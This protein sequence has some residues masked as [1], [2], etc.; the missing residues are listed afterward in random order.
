MGRRVGWGISAYW[1]QPALLH[2]LAPKGED[3]LASLPVLLHSQLLPPLASPCIL[4][5]NSEDES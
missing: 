1:F 3:S 4:K 2:L 5:S